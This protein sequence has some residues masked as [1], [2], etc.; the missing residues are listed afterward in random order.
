MCSTL[1]CV[2]VLTFSSALSC[3]HQSHAG[4]LSAVTIPAGAHSVVIR[5]SPLVADNFFGRST[6][7]VVSLREHHTTPHYHQ[8]YIAL[9]G[10]GWSAGHMLYSSQAIRKC[11]DIHRHSVC[12]FV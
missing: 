7:T 4:Y 5:E 10:V 3:V 9:R 12:G 2:K 8:L 6:L 11:V 1:T